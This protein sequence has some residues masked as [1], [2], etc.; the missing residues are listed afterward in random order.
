MTKI[1]REEADYQEAE[2]YL[3][4]ARNT[5]LTAEVKI[6]NMYP[7]QPGKEM[8]KLEKIRKA[9]DDYR[10]DLETEAEEVRREVSR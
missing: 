3:R 1:R 6:G 10:W 2:A 8:R 4:V 9:L 5:L 7:K